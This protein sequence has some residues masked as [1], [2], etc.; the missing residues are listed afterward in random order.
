MWIEQ[1]QIHKTNKIAGIH[2][3][4]KMIVLLLYILAYFLLSTIH[5]HTLPL[6]SLLTY[7]FLLIFAYISGIGQLL[8]KK[9]R[10]IY[11]LVTIVFLAQTL[12]FPGKTILYSLGFFHIYLESLHKGFVLSI[13]ILNISSILL[14]FFLT[15]K[16]NEW[17]YA[18]SSHG[19][20][21]QVCFVLLST[22]QTIEQLRLRSQ[23]I[24]AAQQARGL[25]FN[26]NLIHRAKAFLPSLIPI[27]LSTLSENSERVL[28][29]EAKGLRYN[30]AHTQIVTIQKNGYETAVLAGAFVYLFLVL[31]VVFAL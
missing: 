3:F 24:L 7:P 31:G 15:T 4:A 19:L 29:L 12:L 21:Q 2:P 25:E 18:L 14:W 20:N 28:T 30:G 10:P 17:I 6:L 1:V 8:I 9:S 26:G 11:F 5:I 13:S 23:R 16:N 27:I 22:F